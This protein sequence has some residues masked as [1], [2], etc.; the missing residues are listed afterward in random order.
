MAAPSPPVDSPPLDEE[1]SELLASGVDIYVATRDESLA[2]EA[3]FALGGRIDAD[4]RTFTV[5][6]PEVMAAATLRNV[7]ANG[8]LA[9]NLSRPTDHK[10]VQLKGRAIGVRSSTEADRHVQSLA[11]SALIEQFAAIGI[12]RA[13]SRRLIWWPSVAIEMTVEHVYQQ[14]P[15]PGAGEPLRR[16]DRG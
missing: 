11:R 14:T 5:Y 7:K 3:T 9:V 6:V 15:G 4:R 1:L 8:Q 13:A 10:C 12:P 16:E 2:P